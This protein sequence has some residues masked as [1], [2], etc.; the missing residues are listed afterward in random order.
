MMILK[1]IF[2]DYGSGGRA[3]TG[4]PLVNSEMLYHWATPEYL[5][6]E[7]FASKEFKLASLSLITSERFWDYRDEVLVSQS[8]NSYDKYF[9]LQT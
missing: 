9:T 7:L 1:I 6:Y 8:V 3:R 2:R 4:N 5:F